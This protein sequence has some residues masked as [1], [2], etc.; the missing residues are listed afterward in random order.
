MS[1]DRY[2]NGN[3]KIIWIYRRIHLTYKQ[4]ILSIYE[5]KKTWRKKS[6]I[7]QY[8]PLSAIANETD[9]S[10]FQR[11]TDSKQSTGSSLHNQTEN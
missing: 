5:D 3:N 2:T 7:V 1:S 9:I 6:I 10:A 4:L 8:D 11:S